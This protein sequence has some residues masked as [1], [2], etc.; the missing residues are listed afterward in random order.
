MPLSGWS[1]MVK[2]LKQHWRQAMAATTG[3]GTSGGGNPWR[4]IG[5]GTAGF[6]LLLPL[7]AM[8]FTAEV[9]WT[10]SDFIFAG[11][12]FALAGGILEL[13]AWRSV[14]WLYRTA[15]G[16]A[17]AAGF[18]HL[19]I[20]G[21]VGIIGSESNPGNLIYLA[22]VAIALL[23]SIVAFGRPAAMAWAMGFTAI[24]E[25]LAP[26]IAYAALADPAGDV[27]KPE[28]FTCA[29]VFAGMWVLSALLFRKA[30]RRDR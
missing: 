1:A 21:A 10:V 25:V 27:L 19:W 13:A 22:V 5:W 14:S 17:V 29:V 15:V 11:V 24:V 20:T 9:N 28:V 23:G 8:Q 18:L 26:V 6:L 12:M 30:A 2:A 4:M 16:I 3:K 7:V